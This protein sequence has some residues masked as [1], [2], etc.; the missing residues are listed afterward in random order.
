MH[1]IL[2]RGGLWS[3]QKRITHLSEDDLFL[4]LLDQIAC[5]VGGY[6]WG[7]LLKPLPSHGYKEAVIIT[8]S[9]NI[10]IKNQE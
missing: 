1:S 2:G 4:L 3:L 8:W 6:T 10:L 9:I 7:S 5:F